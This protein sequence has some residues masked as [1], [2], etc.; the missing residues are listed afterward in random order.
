MCAPFN[1]WMILPLCAEFHEFY[2][3]P[4]TLTNLLT[5]DN[6]DKQIYMVEVTTVPKIMYGNGPSKNVKYPVR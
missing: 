1:L 2:A 3:I 5:T 6:D 4:A